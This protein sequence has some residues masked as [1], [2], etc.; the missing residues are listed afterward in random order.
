MSGHKWC[1]LLPDWTL[2]GEFQS[3]LNKSHGRMYSPGKCRESVMQFS[4][5]KSLTGAAIALALCSSPTMAAAATAPAPQPLNPLV[6]VSVFGTQ[7][8]AQIVAQ[9]GTLAAAQQ[10]VPGG[11][12]VLPQGDVPPPPPPPGKHYGFGVAPV[13]LGLVGIA[14]LALLIAS[15]DDHDNNAPASPG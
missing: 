1:N 15:G 10:T 13:I 3:Y 12:P 2:T 5:V 7:A 9:S 14:V 11:G 6:A 8:S 4:R